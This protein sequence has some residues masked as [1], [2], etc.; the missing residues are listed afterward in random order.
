MYQDKSQ[1]SLN[2]HRIAKT[3]LYTSII[4]LC[5]GIGNIG[6]G[7]IKYNEYHNAL[8]SIKKDFRAMES[9]KKLS[10]I[11]IN[12]YK[13]KNTQQI[14]KIRAR[15]SF[16]DFVII[17]G[18]VLLG[19]AGILLLALLMILAPTGAVIEEDSEDL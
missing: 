19:A 5:L 6:F 13:R 18:K 15:I 14:R 4:T 9:D 1:N 3:L 16:Y 8:N 12:Q 10:A 7:N 2:Q 17:G 11:D